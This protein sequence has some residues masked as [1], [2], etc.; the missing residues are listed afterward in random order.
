MHDL[1]T[2]QTSAI[3]VADSLQTK[4]DLQW[5]AHRWNDLKARLQPQ[6]T[7]NT[8]GTRPTPK[9][10]PPINLHISNLLFEIE[11]EARMMGHTLL[12]ETPNWR[13]RSSTMPQLLLDVAEQH[14]HWTTQD[15]QTATTFV[16][17]AREYRAKTEHALTNPPNPTYIGPCQHCQNDLYLN[18]QTRH[19]QCR[20]CTNTVDPQRQMQWVH[21]QLTTRLMTLAEI[22]DALTILDMPTPYRTIQSWAN[23]GKIEKQDCGKYLLADAI[24]LATK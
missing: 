8:G 2:I 17:W 3:S 20:G 6:T 5:I 12:Q 24:D 15:D 18:P 11:Y 10:K 13:P 16:S 7:P 21:D 22:R 23:R 1:T 14:G 9:S 19:A 4:T